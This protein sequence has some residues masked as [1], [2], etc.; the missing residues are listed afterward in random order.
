MNISTESPTL[1]IAALALFVIVGSGWWIGTFFW[2]LNGRSPVARGRAIVGAQVNGVLILFAWLLRPAG[3]FWAV[4]APWYPPIALYAFSGDH[5][6]GTIRFFALPIMVGIAV[7]VALIALCLLVR[8]LRLF[9][10]GLAGFGGLAAA[11]VVAVSVT[12][13]KITAQAQALGAD[14]IAVTPLWQS[15]KIAGEIPQFNL[16]AVARIS[17]EWH[18]FSYAQ[19]TFYSLP[20]R[21]NVHEIPLINECKPLEP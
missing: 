18:G 7:C 19:G 20:P 13:G 11:A 4:I 1:I 2:H 12:P 15:R 5:L 6:S 14:C 10:V 21:V 17:G 16:H 9:T 8:P 3:W